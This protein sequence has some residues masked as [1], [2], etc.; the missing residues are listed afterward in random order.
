MT[1]FDFLY[2]HRVALSVTGT[3]VAQHL[4]GVA[5]DSVP[6]LPP[7]SGFWKTWGYKVFQGISANYK[8]AAVKET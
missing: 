6:P 1:V 7:T 8:K 2:S 5:A 4:I 3:A